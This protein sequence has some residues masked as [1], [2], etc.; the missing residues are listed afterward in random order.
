[1]T[2][3]EARDYVLKQIVEHDAD[4]THSVMKLSIEL[5]IDLLKLGPNEVGKF[6]DKMLDDGLGALIE[7]GIYGYKIDIDR[8]QAGHIVAFGV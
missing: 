1:M 3:I 6:A 2:G 7:H 8:K 4:G 5:A